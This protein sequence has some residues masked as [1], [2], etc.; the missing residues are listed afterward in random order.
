MISSPTLKI[1]STTF[2]FESWQGRPQQ[3]RPVIEAMTRLGGSKLIKQI[4]KTEAVTT[5]STAT[6]F[7]AGLTEKASVEALESAWRSI[8]TNFGKSGTW[9]DENGIAIANITVLD[10]TRSIR[11]VDG[12][13]KAMMT[14]NLTLQVDG[15]DLDAN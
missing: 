6:M 8:R 3:P 11:V 7:A 1:G 9:T 15:D 13:S 4:I 2:N 5:Q 14:M 10:G 12:I